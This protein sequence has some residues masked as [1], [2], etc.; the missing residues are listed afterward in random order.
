MRAIILSLPV[1]ILLHGPAVAGS[2]TAALE[3]A[4]A[5]G[6]FAD[7]A[8]LDGVAVDLKYAS[9]INAFGQNVYGDFHTA[10]LRKEAAAALAR[11]AKSL[12]EAHPGYKLLV[13]DALRPR[14]VQRLFWA[15]VKGTPFQKYVADPDKGSVHNYGMAVDISVMDSA[16]KELDMGTPYDGFTP[17]AQP[18]M[19]DENLAKGL[20]TQAQM[21]NRTILRKAMTGAGFIQNPLEWWHYDAAPREKVRAKYKIVE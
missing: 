8:T 6:E 1:I 17:L 20:L 7:L 9:D 2:S 14:S 16:G 5:S 21:A 10:L 11:A 12:G 4:A 15:K 18:R 13:F 3:S 19:E